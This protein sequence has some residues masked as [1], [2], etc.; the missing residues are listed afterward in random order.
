MTEIFF[1]EALYTT[2]PS[3]ERLARLQQQIVDAPY[4][5]VKLT[6]NINKRT[7]LTFVFCLSLLPLIAKSKGKHL[8]I[9]CNDKLIKIMKKIGCLKKKDGEVLPKTNIAN[10]LINNSR[11]IKTP[12]DIFEFVP[13]ITKEAPVEM[14]EKL[15]DIFTSKVGEM[16]NNSIEHSNAEYVIGEK[17]YKYQKNI[18]CFSC[19]DTGVGIPNK[20][21]KHIGND[22]SQVDAFK[23]AMKK[24]NSTANLNNSVDDKIPRGLG[25]E[26]LKSFAKLNH[27]AIR[28]CSNNVL[29]INDKKGEKYYSMKEEFIGTLLEMDIIADNNHRY[30]IK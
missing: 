27:G 30:I 12:N 18:Y 9:F 15:I 19:Y 8:S 11:I 16:Y 24:G 20:V 25:L 3:F 14:S 28:I 26:L 29:Y 4:N 2:I 6:L 7:G 21:L 13:E 17:Y 10:I 1:D 5:C 22:F 23:W